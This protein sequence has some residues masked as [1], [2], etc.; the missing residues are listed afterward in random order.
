MSTSNVLIKLYDLTEGQKLLIDAIKSRRY[1]R[2]LWPARV[3]GGKTVGA[4]LSMQLL[5][6]LDKLEG[7]GNQQYILGGPTIDSI[8]RNQLP[9]WRDIAEQLG[10]HF[11]HNRQLNWYEVEGARFQLF[12]GDNTGSEARVQGY[13]GSAAYIDEITKCHRSFV[14]QVEY[15]LAGFEHSVLL[16]TMN[17]DSPYHWIKDEWI[18]DAPTTTY[19]INGASNHHIS[20]ARWQGIVES[21]AGGSSYRR[22][23]ME[24]W[25][26]EGGVVFDITEDMI[27]PPVDIEGK[28]AGVVGLDV[29]VSGVTAGIL[30]VNI[31]RQWVIA[32]EYT[33]EGRLLGVLSEEQH[34]E[35]MEAKWDIV[36]WAIDPAAQQFIERVRK[37]GY[38]VFE[39]ENDILKG[40]HAFNNALSTGR[41]KVAANC[42]ALLSSAANYTWNEKTE[43]PNKNGR[44]HWC[45]GAR[46]GTCHLLPPTMTEILL[47]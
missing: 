29:G 18:D 25:A 31:N 39:A 43:K 1:T 21:N 36:E 46:Y 13:T 24:E 47:R 26:A 4:V 22:N 3:R 44:E 15:R 35:N 6:V 19:L 30:F 45:D 42:R 28:M 17:H 8:N 37:N 33:W 32:D 5:S 14:E 20:E 7:H 10:L 41:L 23:I 11:Q 2:I 34:I 12:S 27:V 40:V 16:G 38:M 9:Y